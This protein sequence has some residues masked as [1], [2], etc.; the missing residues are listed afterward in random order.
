LY[1]D[2]LLGIV[3]E[4]TLKVNDL[5]Y[6]GKSLYRVTDQNAMGSQQVKNEKKITSAHIGTPP[7]SFA[8]KISEG[9]RR[10]NE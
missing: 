8:T 3:T 5:M 9:C 7:H 6:D 10:H 4:G 2:D 1:E